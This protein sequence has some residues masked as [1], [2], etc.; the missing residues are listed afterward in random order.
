M[1]GEDGIEVWLGGVDISA[2]LPFGCGGNAK[3][4]SYVQAIGGSGGGRGG[5]EVGVYQNGLNDRV[6]GF[7]ELYVR[8]IK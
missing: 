8:L 3:C 4:G 2:R 1:R 5:L 6:S 7:P